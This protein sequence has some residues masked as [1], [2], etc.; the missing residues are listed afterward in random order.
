[1]TTK[2]WSQDQLETAFITTGTSPD[3]EIA[4]PWET[5]LQDNEYFLVNFHDDASAAVTIDVN[6]Q[7][8]KA[9]EDEDGNPVDTITA[10]QDY[11]IKRDVSKDAFVVVGSIG[12]WTTGTSGNQYL[13]LT[14]TMAG[15]P[16]EVDITDSRITDITPYLV[17]FETQPV[18]NITRTLT[19]GNLNI[20]SDDNADTLDVTVVFWDIGPAREYMKGNA[21]LTGAGPWTVTDPRITATTPAFICPRT[22][23]VGYITA[24]CGAGVMT[25][26]STGTEVGVIVD[27]IIT[28]DTTN[29]S[30][31]MP[32]NATLDDDDMFFRK[33]NVSGDDEALKW[34]DIKTEINTEISTW[35]NADV[36]I[37]SRVLNG[38]NGTVTYNHSLW[39]IPKRITFVN[40]W[41]T[42][43]SIFWTYLA[44]WT[45]KCLYF[46]SVY[47][48]ASYAI[49]F[50]S[51][52]WVTYAIGLV[53]NVTS[54]TFDIVWTKDGWWWINETANIKV[55]LD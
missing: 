14:G 19:S 12:G 25:I 26:S 54:T 34:S 27:Y 29:Y 40:V 42:C 39:R 31:A 43:K 53:Q 41:T 6:S 5:A 35:T 23:P 50:S 10:D 30:D 47:S 4:K 9:L 33:G 24:T 44:G 3:F 32:Y 1:M 2:V 11:R 8:A 49:F 48:T 45:Q 38:T 18:G 46:D 7:W 37:I 36:I 17:F 28:L 20:A 22:T 55:D 52:P 13:L 51:N 21:T 15:T 16:P